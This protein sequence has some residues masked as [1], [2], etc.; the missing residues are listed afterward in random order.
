MRSSNTGAVNEGKDPAIPLNP[1]SAVTITQLIPE[2]TGNSSNC[3]SAHKIAKLCSTS[4]QLRENLPME[5]SHEPESIFSRKSRGGVAV[6][7][8]RFSAKNQPSPVPG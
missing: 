6:I 1:S 2:S 7:F 3:L 4:S 5:P 8:P